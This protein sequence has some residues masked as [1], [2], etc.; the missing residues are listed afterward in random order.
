MRTYCSMY[1]YMDP[2]RNTSIATVVLFTLFT[3][4]IRPFSA[5]SGLSLTTFGACGSPRGHRLP[6]GRDGEVSA[7]EQQ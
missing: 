3:M 1:P 4:D 7:M 6:R 5:L 2:I